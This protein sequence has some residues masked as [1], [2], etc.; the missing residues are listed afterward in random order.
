MREETPHTIASLHARAAAWFEAAALADAAI[1]HWLAAGEVE[2][3][4][5]LVE[6]EI[7]PAF[8]REDWPTV[9]RWLTL[10]PE[11]TIH[12]TCRCSWRRA[13]AHSAWALVAVD[14]DRAHDRGA[15]CARRRSR[16]RADGRSRGSGLDA[17]RHTPADPDRPGAGA[18]DAAGGHR[19]V[20]PDRRY[21]YGLAWT[22]YGMA[23]QAA[24]QGHEA[25]EQLARSAEAGDGAPRRRR[26]PQALRPPLRPLA[27]RQPRARPEHRADHARM[28]SRHRLPLSA[29][30]GRRFLGDVLYERD[31]LEG[32]IEQYA[33]VARDYESFHLTGVREAFFGLGPGLPRGGPH[34]GGLARA[35]AWPRDPARCGG[36]G[37][38]S[39]PG[40]LRGLP[41]LLSGDLPRAVAWA[42]DSD[43]GVDSA[44]LYYV[45]HP[46]VIRAAILCAAG[47]AA[48]LHAATALLEE[49]RQRAARAHFTERWCASRRCWRS[50]T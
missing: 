27:G 46:S 16:R 17:A 26:D 36:A 20:P 19:Q 15:A 44:S 47:D 4:V 25:V 32:A 29:S 23:L 11:E 2:T 34:G 9:T 43:V 7:Q 3:A 30:W 12:T 21:Q 1:G 35:A 50:R 28:A 18:G 37:A 24:G 22:L 14:G 13:A 45:V 42:R 10:L 39:G 49:V 31:D 6:R 8:D 48:S 5:A 33:I 38:C 41:G 40:G